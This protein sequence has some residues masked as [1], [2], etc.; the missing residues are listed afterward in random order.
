MAQQQYCELYR[1]WDAGGKLLYVGISLSSVGRLA[2]HRTQACWARSIAKVTIQRFG[3]V[4]QALEAERQAIRTERPVHNKAHAINGAADSAS[5]HSVERGLDEPDSIRNWM[6]CWTP[7]I[8]WSNE[9]SNARRGTGELIRWPSREAGSDRWVLATGACD[10]HV[11]QMTSLE[12]RH[13]VLSTF[14]GIVAGQDLLPMTAH[15]LFWPIREYRLGLPADTACP[16][17]NHLFGR[18]AGDTSQSGGES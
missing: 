16:P 2:Q 1:H 7:N 8:D 14:A 18:V 17:S 12:R 4:D 10:L 15:A 5:W 11:H 9:L 3:S 13:F 6:I